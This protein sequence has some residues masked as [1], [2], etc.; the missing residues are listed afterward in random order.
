MELV[1]PKMGFQANFP[2]KNNRIKKDTAVQKTKP[3]SGVTNSI[4][5]YRYLL[6]MFI[7]FNVIKTSPEPI[8]PGC[9][10]S[11]AL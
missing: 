1:T 2:N 6:Y 9:S 8:A 5:L 3:I 10:F 4:I 11:F 7:L